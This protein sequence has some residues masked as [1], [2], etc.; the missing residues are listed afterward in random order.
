MS[1][2]TLIAQPCVVDFALPPASYV[3]E[4]AR[5]GRA[6]PGSRTKSSR[7]KTAAPSFSGTRRRAGARRDLWRW[8]D[9]DP[10]AA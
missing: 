5:N 4:A 6:T 8:F 3:A 10:V 9:D 1:A 2:L 7:R